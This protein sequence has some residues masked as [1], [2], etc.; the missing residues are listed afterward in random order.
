MSANTFLDDHFVFTQEI[1][2]D[3]DIICNWFNLI[4]LGFYFISSDQKILRKEYKPRN[5]TYY[6]ALVIAGA[7]TVYFIYLVSI[8]GPILMAIPD[9]VQAL[10][11][12]GRDVFNGAK[13]SAFLNI[14]LC[15]L[16]VIVWRSR[17]FLYFL[18]LAFPLSL[19]LMAKGRMIVW[20]SL[21]FAYLN[22]VAISKKTG[23][24]I[25]IPLCLFL[26]STVLFR[27]DNLDWESGLD[28][29]MVLLFSDPVNS[30]FSTPLVYKDYYEN[31]D[32][33]EYL[34]RSFFNFLPDVI[35]KI[36]F[37]YEDRQGL[38]VSEIIANDY[39]SKIGFSLGINLPSEAIY[40]GGTPFAF[41]SPFI[42]GGITYLLNRFGIYKTFPGFIFLCFYISLLRGI[43][44]GTFYDNFMPIIY[45]M[46]SYL[47]WM[48]V[49]EWGRLIF[50]K[51]RQIPIQQS[52]L[53]SYI[54]RQV[55]SMEK[56]D[57]N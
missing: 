11:V 35:N 33:G 50:I 22:Y 20:A 46:F 19:D 2:Q 24:I 42:I 14:F 39:S 10:E 47:I 6:L 37:G 51:D 5:S 32:L 54:S 13:L 56:E 38:N 53:N 31:G 7:T 3:T 36:I 30:R 40:Y 18:L 17:N 8:F 12:F 26:I 52:F 29:I 41:I 15:S 57:K 27:F 1:L 9:R 48:T 43:V 25:A 34:L 49:L 16:A 45:W 23:F 4:F 21:L 28:Q 55:N 44:R